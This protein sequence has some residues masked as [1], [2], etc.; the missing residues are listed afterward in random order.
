MIGK[1][2][3]CMAE[4]VAK[5]QGAIGIGDVRNGMLGPRATFNKECQALLMCSE[6]GDVLRQNR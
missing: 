2:I 1:Y 4:A 3:D 6:G 5:N